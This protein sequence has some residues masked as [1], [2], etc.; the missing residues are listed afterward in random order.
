MNEYELGLTQSAAENE[1]E[2]FEMLMTAAREIAQ[3]QEQDFQALKDRPWYKSLLKTLT[4][5]N[6]SEQK[7]L[8]AKDISS[9]SKLNEITWRALYLLS[10]SS[11]NMAAQIE[12]NAANIEQ[13]LR[14]QGVLFDSVKRI[15][16]QVINA[17]SRS[18]TEKQSAIAD[19]AKPQF[20]CGHALHALQTNAGTAGVCAAVSKQAAAGF[21]HS[22]ARG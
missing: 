8:L 15:V 4:F 13:L 10:K 16:E 12:Q 20:V 21:E 19:G 3:S 14:Q 7:K 18:R 11:A 2:T 22:C 6:S 1:Q 17:Q 9:L 5:S